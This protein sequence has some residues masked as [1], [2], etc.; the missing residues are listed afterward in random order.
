MKNSA[1]LF[2]TAAFALVLFLFA[3]SASAQIGGPKTGGFKEIPADD[4]EARAAAEFAVENRGATQ[5]LEIGLTDVSKAESQ[6]VA[7][8]N[9]RLCLK[10][11]VRAKNSNE[12]DEVQT[13]QVVVY[14]NLQRE[15]KLTS[16]KEADCGED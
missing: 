11:T 6:V 16:W 3:A 10:I 15:Y 1:L 13:V 5:N 2:F 7:G 4:P 14:R 8:V 9:Y 12:A